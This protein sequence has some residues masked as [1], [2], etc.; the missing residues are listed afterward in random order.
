MRRLPARAPGIA[1]L[2]APLARGEA[3]AEAG[4]LLLFAGGD[5]VALDRARP[6]LSTFA[7]EINYLGGLGTGQ[8][9]KAANNYLLWTCLAATVEA[10]D[11]GASQGVDREA[12]RAALGRS[13]G[14]NWAMETRADERPA[15]WAE[16]DMM[17]LLAEADRARLAM[18]LAGAVKEAIKAFKIARNLP[19]PE[20]G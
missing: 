12:M 17:S 16:K 3:A 1:F 19:M 10:L 14:A 6:A 8:A 4:D 5:P 15:L 20:E 2:D 13:S 11:F 18:P 7:S 9:A